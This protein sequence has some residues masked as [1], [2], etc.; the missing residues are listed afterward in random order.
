MR[1]YHGT[2]GQPVLEK[3]LARTEMLKLFREI[4]MP[5]VYIIS[6][7][8]KALKQIPKSGSFGKRLEEGIRRLNS[9]LNSGEAVNINSPKQLGVILLIS[10]GFHM[11][12]RQKQDILHQ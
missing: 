6:Y 10:L 9:Q 12:K 8:E 2:T 5:L 7:G 1:N 3:E 11:G 4:E